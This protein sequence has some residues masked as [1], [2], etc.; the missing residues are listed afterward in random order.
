MESNGGMFIINNDGL[1]GGAKLYNQ[2]ATQFD[3]LVK[4]LDSICALVAARWGDKVGDVWKEKYPLV[5]K[6]LKSVSNNLNANARLFNNVADVAA[7]HQMRANAQI[8]KIM[9]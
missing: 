5:V 3:E 7:E 8:N 2:S 6:E 4:Q 1:I 9:D